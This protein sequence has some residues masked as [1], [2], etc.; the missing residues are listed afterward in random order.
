[1]SK[2]AER[3]MNACTLSMRAFV[4]CNRDVLVCAFQGFS[5]LLMINV[6]FRDKKYLDCHNTYIN[7]TEKGQANQVGRGTIKDSAQTCLELCFCCILSKS[8]TFTASI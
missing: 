2:H 7:E 4:I 1:M 5:L 8:Y 6:L 3:K